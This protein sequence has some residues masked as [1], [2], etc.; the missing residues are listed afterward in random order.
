MAFIWNSE[1]IK[2]SCNYFMLI[3][4]DLYK[5]QLWVKKPLWA[6][7]K[8]LTKSV[9]YKKIY[10]LSC[11]WVIYSFPIQGLGNIMEEPAERR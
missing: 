11:G 9:K 5:S 10:V 1:A 7:G 4:I 3:P 2:I 8:R 6:V